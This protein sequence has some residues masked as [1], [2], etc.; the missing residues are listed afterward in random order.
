MWSALWLRT[1][2]KM[3]L[4]TLIPL[5]LWTGYAIC[6]SQMSLCNKHSKHNL[7]VP[8]SV[9]KQF[10]LDSVKLFYLSC[11]GS[12]KPLTSGSDSHESWLILDG[13]IYVSLLVRVNK[14]HVFNRL[15][16]G[17]FLWQLGSKNSKF[18]CTSPLQA[19]AFIMLANI[20][21]AKASHKA[22]SR[23]KG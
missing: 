6:I 22:K 1:Q 4:L 23:F 19:S 9:S 21:L 5:Q 11:L 16:Q 13:L 3:V 18:E 12:L 14:L 8:D 2:Q 15:T 7:L 20:P 17:V 10:E